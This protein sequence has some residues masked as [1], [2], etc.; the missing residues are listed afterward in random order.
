[1]D[2]TKANQKVYVIDIDGTILHSPTSDYTQSTPIFDRISKINK[3]YDEGHTI[4]YWTARGAQSGRDWGQ[5]TEQQLIDFGCKFTEVR[6]GKPHYD[7][8]ID[9]KAINDKEYFK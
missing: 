4:I 8:W 5:Y 6:M 7:F 1:M 3:L 2:K 9:D